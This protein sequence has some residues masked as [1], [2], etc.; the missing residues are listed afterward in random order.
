MP[1]EDIVDVLV[2]EGE[3]EGGGAS[4]LRHMSL[5]DGLIRTHTQQIGT[6]GYSAPEVNRYVCIHLLYT[7]IYVLYMCIYV[8]YMCIHVYVHIYLFVCIHVYMYVCKHTRGRLGRWAIVHP[9]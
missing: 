6:L 2:A 1:P 4:G 8:L 7:C 9:K 5:S 3:E